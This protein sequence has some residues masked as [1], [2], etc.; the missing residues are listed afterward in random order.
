[1]KLAELAAYL[2]CPVEG[3][4]EV[5]IHGV[6]PLQQAGPGELSFVE[7]EKFYPLL[8]VTRAEALIL[9]P[10]VPT[11]DIPCLRTEHP[12]LIFARALELFYRPVHPAPGIHPT[13]VVGNNVRLGQDVHLGAHVVVADDVVLGDGVIVYP[14]CTLYQGVRVGAHTVIHANCAIQERTEIGSDC[15][16]QSGAV[17]GAEGFGFVPTADGSWYKMQQSGHVVLGDRVE[18]GAN[19]TIDRPAIGETRI[20]NGVK[21]DNQVMIGHGVQVGENS[22]LVSQ[23]GLAGGAKIGRNV[24]LAGQVGVADHINVGDRVIASAK[25]G[26]PGDVEA[27]MVISGYPALPNAVWRRASAIYRRLPELY[28]TIR[29]L[30]RQV[31]DLQSRVGTDTHPDP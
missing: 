20:S 5:E 21:I 25:T 13:A 27:G 6:A 30:Q 4:A 9:G 11:P 1:M 2:G 10:K 31:A 16:F 24:I 23:V 8:K 17:I 28:Q 7:G 26:I 14:N 18:V 19:T 29:T 15:V 22:L 3:N 12:R